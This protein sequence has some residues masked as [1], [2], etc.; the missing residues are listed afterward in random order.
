MWALGGLCHRPMVTVFTTH[1]LVMS[2]GTSKA[3]L[4]RVR[5][6]K[7]LRG[8]LHSR[9]DD[10]HPLNWG[11]FPLFRVQTAR[12]PEIYE[13]FLRGSAGVAQALEIHPHTTQSS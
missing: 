2:T 12:S 8:L 10:S 11:L 4:A 5:Q 9:L 1:G 13:H 7:G 6:V 3:T